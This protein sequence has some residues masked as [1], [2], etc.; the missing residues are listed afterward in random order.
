MT[1]HKSFSLLWLSTFRTRHES[2]F[3][4]SLLS[5]DCIW[6]LLLPDSGS[7]IGEN[8]PEFSFWYIGYSQTI[9]ISRKWSIKF[10][11]KTGV[12]YCKLY[13]QRH[14]AIRKAVFLPK[15]DN[16]CCFNTI[17]SILMIKAM[18]RLSVILQSSLCVTFKID[19]LFQYEYLPAMSFSD[20]VIVKLWHL[21]GLECEST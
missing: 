5:H 14:F 13:I 7:K 17:F 8:C 20:A 9:L 21:L 2:Q 18:S 19:P 10:S 12:S 1:Y 16:I 11:S 3:H 6:T 15:P 4:S